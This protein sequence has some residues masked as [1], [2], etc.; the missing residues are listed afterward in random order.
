MSREDAEDAV[1]EAMLRVVEDPRA[2]GDRLS[3]WLMAVT[4][5]LCA[6]R[7]RQVDREAGAASR[8][9]SAAPAPVPVEEVVCDR[10]E[11][12]WLA[13]RSGALPARQAE[14]LWL[15]AEGLDVGQVARRMGLSYG[16]AESLL[17]RARRT[18]RRSLAGTL[19]LALWLCGRGRIW[20]GGSGGAAA[21]AVSTAAA[22]AVLGFTLPPVPGPAP[23]R[24]TQPS[25]SR[26]DDRPSPSPVYVVY[27]KG[28]VAAPASSAPK[29]QGSPRPS[30][31]RS[32]TAPSDVLPEL[33]EPSEQPA[34]P[35][36]GA[37]SVP[38]LPSVPVL[39]PVP[40]HPLDAHLPDVKRQGAASPPRPESSGG[41]IGTGGMGSGGP[42]EGFG[43]EGSDG[44]D[45][46]GGP[47][48]PDGS[49]GSWLVGGRVGAGFAGGEPG[50]WD[51]RP[52]GFEEGS[53][54]G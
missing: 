5:R 46:S 4:E 9:A 17:A 23:S 32:G 8:S 31:T 47:D 18:M 36:V 33:P 35:S 50:C 52:F 40:A 1:H 43:R 42:G 30:T 22:V 39:V 3:T 13:R 38:P 45:A 21:V 54:C 20:A 51:G 12:K 37:V 29:S 19:A 34:L 53:S 11:A 10:A 2:E 49:D 16:T 7:Y 26:P 14:A 41:A 48:G 15:K 44:S 28:G 24:Q 27:E 6:D 25:V